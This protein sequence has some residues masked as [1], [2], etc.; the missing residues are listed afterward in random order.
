MAISIKPAVS[1]PTDRTA[2]PTVII[3]EA[4][5]SAGQASATAGTHVLIIVQNLPVPLDRRVWLECQAA[6][7]AT[8]PRC[9]LTEIETRAPARP[10]I[11]IRLSTLKS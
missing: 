6:R 5:S 8:C 4:S 11:A 10:N 1:V 9:R 2:A 3:P 7:Y